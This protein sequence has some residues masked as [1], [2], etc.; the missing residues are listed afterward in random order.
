MFFAKRCRF[1][2]GA[3]QCEKFVILEAI[4]FLW[5][6]SIFRNLQLLSVLILAVRLLLVAAQNCVILLT[7]VYSYFWIFY[8]NI[9]TSIM[10]FFFFLIF[11]IL[12]LMFKFNACYWLLQIR[13]TKWCRI[14]LSFLLKFLES[15]FCKRFKKFSPLLRN[16][17]LLDK[18]FNIILMPYFADP[19][20]AVVALLASIDLE[21]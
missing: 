21:N 5:L 16:C 4:N 10:F 19:V 20:V 14:H 15:R 6:S 12:L 8:F 17:R 18:V 1:R 9:D 3:F 7:E 13:Y 2:R 11:F